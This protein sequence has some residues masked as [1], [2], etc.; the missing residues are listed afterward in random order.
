M[1]ERRPIPLPD[2]IRP[3][4]GAGL[5][6]LMDNAGYRRRSPWPMRI[7]GA[8]LVLGCVALVLVW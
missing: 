8:L 2:R 1:S 6:N 7:M 3:L 4:E 5:Y